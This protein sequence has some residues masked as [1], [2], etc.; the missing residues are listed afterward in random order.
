[1][2]L[3]YIYIRCITVACTQFLVFFTVSPAF[4]KES[5]SENIPLHLPDHLTRSWYHYHLGSKVNSAWTHILFAGSFFSQPNFKTTGNEQIFWRIKAV[6]KIIKIPGSSLA[7]KLIPKEPWIQPWRI[8]H[9]LIPE[10]VTSTLPLVK[11]CAPP[12][13]WPAFK[14]AWLC[15]KHPIGYDLKKR[16]R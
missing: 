3:W 9:L 7:W 13:G 12:H 15:G 14:D 16:S 10:D 8:H 1:M 4:P 5:L 6:K 11:S 2:S